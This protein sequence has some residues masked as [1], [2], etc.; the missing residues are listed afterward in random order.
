M[1]L[2]TVHPQ[3]AV[4]HLSNTSAAEQLLETYTDVFQGL[5]SLPSQ[6]HFEVDNTVK[7]VQHTPRKMPLAIKNE[8]KCKLDDMEKRGIIKP[9]DEPTDWISSMV[10]VKKRNKIR[11]CIDPKDLNK[12]LKRNHYPMPTIEEILPR[13]SN[14]KVFSVLDASDGYHQCHLDEESSY[15]TT[16]WTPFQ[17]Y[18]WLRLPFGVKNASEEYQ[19]RQ[20]EALAGIPGIEIVADDILVCGYGDTSDEATRNHNENLAKLLQRC[21]EKKLKLNRR[22]VQLCQSQVPYIGHLLTPIGVKAD[23]E[24]VR[25]VQDMPR[26]T[27]AKGTQQFLGFINYLAKFLP[28]LSDVCEPLRRVSLNESVFTWESQQEDSFNECKRLVTRDPVL[29]YYDVTKPVTIQCDASDKGLGATLLQEGKP[30]AFASTTLTETQQRYAVIEKETLAICFATRKFRDYILCKENVVVETDHKP[31]ESIFNKSLLAA[32]IRL[33]RM[34]LQLQRF[35]LTVKYKKGSEQYIADLLSRATLPKTHSDKITQSFDV[36]FAELDTINHTEYTNVSSSTAKRIQSGTDA[37]PKLQAL[38]QLVL[39]GWPDSREKIPGAVI[40]YWN[41]REEITIQDG[42]LY[43][44]LRMII[45]S[46]MRNEML[47]KIHSSHLGTEACIRKAKDSLFWPFMRNDIK[48]VVENCGVCAELNN[49]QQK[50]PLQTHKLPTRPWSKIAVDEFHF[51]GK[52]YLITVDY[53][54][55]YFEIDQLHSSTTH[56]IVR[57]LQAHFARLGVPDEV[58]TDNNANLVSDEFS[59]FA[60]EWTFDHITSSCYHSISNGKCES[61]VKIA[62]TLMRKATNAGE[63][64]YKALLDWRNTPTVNMASSPVQ[65]LMSRRTKTLLP[66]NEQLLQPEIQNEVTAK[67]QHKRQIAKKFYDKH[68]KALPELQIGQPV[69]VKPHTGHKSQPWKEGICRKKVSDRSYIITVEGHEYRRNR[70]DLRPRKPK[71]NGNN[72]ATPTSS[73][74]SDTDSIIHD[75]PESSNTSLINGDEKRKESQNPK[76][77]RKS[78]RSTQQT[79]PYV[80]I[81]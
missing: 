65:R 34:L 16:M 38:K 10:V 50:E 77:T 81:P 18:R 72:P 63:N 57:A 56:S 69:Y 3:E 6:V 58:I 5:G 73:A 74:G 1:K 31:L 71:E 9:V 60:V 61:A 2:I 26:P 14:A 11:I 43:K 21:R 66:I 23:P 70:I 46:S 20:T 51:K 33:Q 8:V 24:K 68:A 17:K 40:D 47:N 49:N 27:N 7:P 62:K 78:S 53:Y 67:L 19:R 13:L 54:S 41:Y 55:D 28:H 39:E 79:S 12:A 32:P 75:N 76:A 52:N 45:P 35:N 48:T 37:D 64:V 44:G 59:R 22:K 15:L 4:N 80:H 42:I 29:T 30:V 25:A 36:F